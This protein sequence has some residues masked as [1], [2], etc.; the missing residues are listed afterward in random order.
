LIGYCSQVAAK[1]ARAMMSRGFRAI[2]PKT[3]ERAELVR[4]VSAV[5]FKSV[6]LHERYDESETHS[7]RGSSPPISLTEREREVLRHVALGNSLKEIAAGLELSTKTVD[8]YKTRA[9]RK[10]D[11]R[12]RSDF[13]RFAI[14]SGWM[15]ES[16]C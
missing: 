1:D 13:V 9:N 4:D 11:L 16:H 10:L 7:L 15:Q 12:S 3:V 8:T 5:S 14:Q 6:Y 2:V